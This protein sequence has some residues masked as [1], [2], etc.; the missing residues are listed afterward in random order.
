MSRTT[1]HL[2]GAQ[3]DDTPVHQAL[4]EAL[5][6]CLVHADYF[7]QQGVVIADGSDKSHV[8][9]LKY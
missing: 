5:A 3:T 7:G 9:R 6:N 4:R 8:Y 1:A 2:H